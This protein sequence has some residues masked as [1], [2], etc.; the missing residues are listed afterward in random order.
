MDAPAKP[1]RRAHLKLLGAAV[2]LTAWMRAPVVLAQGPAQASEAQLK[3]VFLYRFG[4]FVEWPAGAMPEGDRPFTIGVVGADLVAAEL[5]RSVAG[6]TVQG[7]RV[8][9]RRLRRGE[10]ANGL[11][12]LFVGQAEAPRFA[13][14]AASASGK[15]LL[16]V[17]DS[18]G[19]FGQGSMINF[20]AVED[21]MR[22]DVDLA[23]ADRGKLKI[24]SRLLALAR[25]VVTS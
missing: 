2:T 7:R 4:D 19:A 23:S 18:E 11:Q 9:V 20:V 17:T 10:P 3:A 16:L 21:K 14:M 8:T 12:V 15:P 1:S 22:F 13:E 24:S 5:E 6:R 25:K